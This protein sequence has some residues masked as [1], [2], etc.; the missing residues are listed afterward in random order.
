MAWNPQTL[1]VWGLNVGQL[2][3]VSRRDH[4]ELPRPIASHEKEEFISGVASSDAATVVA[5]SAGYLTVFHQYQ[6]QKVA[7]K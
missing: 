2:G 4:I 6:V 3:A 5:V 7:L 1:W